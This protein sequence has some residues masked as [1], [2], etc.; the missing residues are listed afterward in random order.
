MYSTRH[1]THLTA[2]FEL[3]KQDK[4]ANQFLYI[5]I[6]NQYK[7][8]DNVRSKRR[9]GVDNLLNELLQN[10]NIPDTSHVFFNDD[11]IL[12]DDEAEIASFPLEYLNSIPPSGMPPN[13]LELKVGSIIMLLRNINP[14]RGRRNVKK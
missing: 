1:K 6:P 5:E 3:N 10:K 12:A 11:S 13:Q 2:W 7:F 14:N 9:H 8:N 4:G